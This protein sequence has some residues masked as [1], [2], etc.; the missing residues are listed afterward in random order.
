VSSRFEFFGS[1]S[2][3]QYIPSDSWFHQRDPRARLI[4]FIVLLVG[5][6]FTPTI[7]GL[8][9]GFFSVVLIYILARVPIRPAIK[10]IG[11]AM[12]FILIL[13]ILQLIFTSRAAQP[14][15]LWTI[16]GL[17]ITK[18]ALITALMLIFRFIVLITHLNALVMCLSTAQITAAL[19]HLLKPFEKLGFPVNDVTMIAQITLRYLPLV[20][21]MAEKTAKA[22]AARGGD[23]E[24][25]GF[26]P[27]RQAKR[28]LPL[29]IPLIVNSLKR[30]ETMALAME[31][32]GFNAAE[33]RSSYYQLNMTWK[34]WGLLLISFFMS[35]LILMWIWFF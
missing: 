12:P 14:T 9:F 6:I 7:W 35:T 28:V 34:D 15:I 8:L 19:Y 1:I 33:Q 23:W 20:A 29:I 16:F 21:Q 18:T 24:Q 22:Q 26:N 4:S 11:R 13:A 5:V 25:K 32:R 27:I 2:L 3:G 30:A 10:G 17:E 31:S